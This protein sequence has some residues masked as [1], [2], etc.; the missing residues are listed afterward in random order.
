M[1][2]RSRLE[3]QVSTTYTLKHSSIKIFSLSEIQWIRCRLID[4]TDPLAAI[5]FIKSISQKA[6]PHSL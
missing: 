4:N 2:G 1:V 6:V 5:I 3:E